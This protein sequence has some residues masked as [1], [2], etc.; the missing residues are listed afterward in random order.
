[1]TNISKG[2]YQCVVGT[3]S[4]PNNF[5]PWSVI[6]QSAHQFPMKVAKYKRKKKKKIAA[7]AAALKFHSMKVSL[8]HNVRPEVEVKKVI[9]KKHRN[10]VFIQ[11]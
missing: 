2:F 10:L 3:S 1:M 9:R 6:S 11:S 7:A 4:S 5:V 8:L